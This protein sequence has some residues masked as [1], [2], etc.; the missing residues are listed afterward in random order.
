M[1]TLRK[2]KGFT[3]SELAKMLKMPG[4]F[5]Q[6]IAN[7]ESGRAPFPEKYSKSFCKAFQFS[8]E[9]FKLKQLQFQNPGFKIHK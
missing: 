6:S 9:E 3:Q 4:G 5:S 1:K 2:E 8:E 7:I